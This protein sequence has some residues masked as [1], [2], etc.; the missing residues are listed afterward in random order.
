MIRIILYRGQLGGT[1]SMHY[2][3]TPL[4]NANLY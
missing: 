4:L 2:F 1:T 3:V